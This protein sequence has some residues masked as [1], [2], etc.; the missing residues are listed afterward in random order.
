MTA[1]NVQD[2]REVGSPDLTV[3][4]RRY[5]TDRGI[6]AQ[7]ARLNNLRSLTTDETAAWGGPDSADGVDFV[8]L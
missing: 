6:S 7:V 1:A 5:I 8:N 4:A 3:R 2:W